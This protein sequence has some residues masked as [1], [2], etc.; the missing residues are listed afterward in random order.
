MRF[1][2]DGRKVNYCVGLDIAHS[3]IFLQARARHD[4]TNTVVAGCVTG[5]SM[6]AR[7]LFSFLTTENYSMSL[8]RLL[9]PMI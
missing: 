2:F 4:A 3:S 1:L 9:V 8:L 5:G 7:G 6:S